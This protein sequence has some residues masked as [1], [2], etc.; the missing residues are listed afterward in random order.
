MTQLDLEELWKQKALEMFWV[1]VSLCTFLLSSWDQCYLKRC[2][3][4]RLR[5]MCIEMCTAVTVSI[6]LEWQLFNSRVTVDLRLWMK[7]PFPFWYSLF[8]NNLLKQA[9][10]RVLSCICYYYFSLHLPI[11]NFSMV[12]LVQY[13]RQHICKSG[14]LGRQNIR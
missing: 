3:A 7:F 8:A 14:S 1:Q 13:L 10:L 5:E 12:H 4:W 9:F 11:F 6:Y 2:W